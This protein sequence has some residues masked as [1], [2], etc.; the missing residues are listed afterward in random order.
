VVGRVVLL[1][2]TIESVAIYFVVLNSDFALVGRVY[3]DVID[4]FVRIFE[5]ALLLRS[6]EVCSE[7]RTLLL[8]QMVRVLEI[9]GDI[10]VEQILLVS[11]TSVHITHYK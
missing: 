6:A 11:L 1:T 8:C 2:A 5:V 3:I 4:A 10:V 9:F 7:C